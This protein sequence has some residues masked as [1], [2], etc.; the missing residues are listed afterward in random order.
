[1]LK[2]IKKSDWLLIGIFSAFL[3]PLIFPTFRYP[4]SFQKIIGVLLYTLFDIGL[5]VVFV[6]YLFPKYFPESRF[7]VLVLN[8]FGLL[9]VHYLFREVAFFLILG[10]KMNLGFDGFI[11]GVINNAQNSGAFIAILIAKQLYEAQNEMLTLQKA[12]KENELRWLKS[13]IDPHF[14]FNNLNILDILIHEDPKKA[15]LYT[16]KLSSLYRYLVRQK[17]QD[18]VTLAEEWAFSEDYIFL[19]KQRFDDLFIFENNL[20]GKDLYQYFIPPAAMQIVLENAAKHNVA[21]DDNPIRVSITLEG[22]T[23]FIRNTFRPKKV[24]PEGTNTG[25]A[26]LKARIR[27]MTDKN[28]EINISQ[29]IFEVKIP[30]VKH[31]A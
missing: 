23:L 11:M 4:T 3:M 17:D 15:S 25:L 12:Q 19:L 9:A 6:F 21:A 7:R 14:L 29:D 18:V 26:N 31:V 10:D 13:Q 30:L 16:K 24:K 28:V 27:L 8:L 5:V 1:M 22:Q 20:A 2:R